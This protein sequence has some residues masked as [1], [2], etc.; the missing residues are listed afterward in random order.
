MC[1]LL[2]VDTLSVMPQ[3]AD[4]E[5]RT[6]AEAIRQ[7]AEHHHTKQNRHISRDEYDLL[8]QAADVIERTAPALSAFA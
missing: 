5:N 7:L 8:I 6:L 3:R 4:Y 1:I 2:R